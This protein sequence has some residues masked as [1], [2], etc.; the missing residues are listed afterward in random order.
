MPQFS[1]DLPQVAAILRT[2][3]G[4]NLYDPLQRMFARLR[5]D[6]DEGSS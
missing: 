6:P 2:Y 1:A 5:R 4:A 3:A